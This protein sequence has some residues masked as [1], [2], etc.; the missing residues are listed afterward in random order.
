MDQLEFFLPLSNI[1][2]KLRRKRVQGLNSVVLNG[3]GPF[4]G[5]T[6]CFLS[7]FWVR[8]IPWSRCHCLCL[9]PSCFKR[10]C[11]AI[12]KILNSCFV[13]SEAFRS[14][15]VWQH[16]RPS[17]FVAGELEASGYRKKRAPLF[18]PGS[19]QGCRREGVQETWIQGCAAGSNGALSV[20]FQGLRS[21]LTILTPMW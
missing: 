17:G 16:Q 7:A 2:P 10:L 20:S 15:E 4:K 3:L 19:K 6:I 5:K 11:P 13:S 12:F 8:E 14:W 18:L 9:P 21:L 1:I